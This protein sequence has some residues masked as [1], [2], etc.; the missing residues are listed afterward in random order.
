MCISNIC[1]ENALQMPACL[2][3]VVVV[4]TIVVVVVVVVLVYNYTSYKIY[5]YTTDKLHIEVLDL[6]TRCML[7]SHSR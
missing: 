2:V 7:I 1:L 6:G 4:A 3:V 5:V